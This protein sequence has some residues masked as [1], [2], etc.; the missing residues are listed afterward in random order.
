MRTIIRLVGVG[1]ILTGLLMGGLRLHQDWQQNHEYSRAQQNLRDQ[2]LQPQVGHQESAPPQG[3]TRKDP[4][5]S[6]GK[7]LAVLRIPKFG[8]GYHPVIVEGV[9][10]DALAKG[11]GHYPGTAMPGEIGNFAVA[12]HRTGWG[13][14]F[15]RLDQLKRG[16]SVT[17]EWR[18]RSDTYRITGTRKVKPTEVG[19]VLPVPNRPGVKPDKARITLTTCTDRD[20]V[21][22]AYRL[23]LVVWGELDER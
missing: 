12:G 10:Q 1:L 20:P 18:G 4:G 9:S 23:R 17:V 19:V 2:L 8:A 21:T 11:P 6:E 14:P 3:A 5:P 16:D 22:R 15:N 7:A 13:Q